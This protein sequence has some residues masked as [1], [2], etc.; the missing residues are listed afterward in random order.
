MEVHAANGYLI[1][2]FL[3][4]RTNHRTDRYGGSIENR[5]RFLEE[6]VEGVTSAWPAHRIGVRLSPN[7]AFN[8]MVGD[9]LCSTDR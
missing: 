3:Q 6:V 1:D 7:G 8:D 4:S 9:L 5:C 2:T